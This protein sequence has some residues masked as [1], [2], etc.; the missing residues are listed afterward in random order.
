MRN[1]DLDF[2]GFAWSLVLHATTLNPTVNPKPRV[3]R[4]LAQWSVA[5]EG[6]LGVFRDMD[7]GPGDIG[8]A[9]YE[10]VLGFLTMIWESV[11]QTSTWDPWL[12]TQS[13]PQR[14]LMFR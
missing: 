11:P 6:D 7:L 9:L 8:Y 1:A 3:R 13:L 12:I 10:S 14:S 4:Q 2:L 5:R